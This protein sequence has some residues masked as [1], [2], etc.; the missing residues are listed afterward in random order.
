MWVETFSDAGG[1]NSLASIYQGYAKKRYYD[2]AARS[3]EMEGDYQR[4]RGKFTA[5][6]VRKEGKSFASRQR[7]AMASQGIDTGSGSSLDV[8]ANTASKVELDALM[9]ESEGI[10]GESRARTQAMLTKMQGRREFS[11][12][13][14]T[15][16]SKFDYRWISGAGWKNRDWKTRG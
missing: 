5:R 13:L 16:M 6:Q 10:F 15:G 11:Q 14:F 1:I 3:I 12:G 8:L 2:I 9:A 7:A 4:W